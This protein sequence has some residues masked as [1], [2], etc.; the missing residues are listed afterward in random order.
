MPIFPSN[1]PVI[2]TQYCACK[3]VFLAHNIYEIKV[4]IGGDNFQDDD[5]TDLEDMRAVGE[6]VSDDRQAWV[7]FL[8]AGVV[9]EMRRIVM[10]M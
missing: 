10:R 6:K 4:L 3:S 8:C 5:D 1:T 9:L 7:P 2:F